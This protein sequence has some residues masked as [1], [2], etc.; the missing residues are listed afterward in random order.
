MGIVYRSIII[1][2]SRYLLFDQVFYEDRTKYY[3]SK[4]EVLESF[5]PMNHHRAFS[6]AIEKCK[7]YY[8]EFMTKKRKKSIL[9][10]NTSPLLRSVRIKTIKE[11]LS[12]INAVGEYEVPTF[13]SKANNKS[14]KNNK[15]FAA[16]EYDEEGQAVYP[17]WCWR[18]VKK[19]DA[20]GRTKCGI[21]VKFVNPYYKV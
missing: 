3:T 4:E 9:D 5:L 20:I 2:I 14:Y 18:M 16:D 17:S 15:H 12:L 10:T 7:N 6:E 19:T 13:V 21:V 1:I 11:G 8:A